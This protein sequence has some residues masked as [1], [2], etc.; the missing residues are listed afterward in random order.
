M[1]ARAETPQPQHAQAT[2][3]G[4][5]G[6]VVAVPSAIARGE[7]LNAVTKLLR[8]SL[9][10]EARRRA[11]DAS[12]LL[13]LRRP[14]KKAKV[15]EPGSEGDA[16]AAAAHAERRKKAANK[17][18]AKRK[19]GQSKAAQ[20]KRQAAAEEP[21]PDDAQLAP[22]EMEADGGSAGAEDGMDV[23]EVAEGMGEEEEEEMGEE[24]ATPA[25]TAAPA[26]PAVA[27]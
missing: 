19:K 17:A 21:Q 2:A 3:T 18:K 15:E 23:D 10:W 9:P 12:H 6:G 1:A 25:T 14:T 8:D 24:Y 4:A 7:I 27:C 13:N 22:G 26:S 20:R 5:A 16:A 11:V